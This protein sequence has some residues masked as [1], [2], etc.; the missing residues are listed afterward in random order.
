MLA[1]S[2]EKNST[3]YLTG[4]RIAKCEDS[5]SDEKDDESEIPGRFHVELVNSRITHL[6]GRL[7]VLL[8]RGEDLVK[9]SGS[10]IRGA[11]NFSLALRS[12][13]LFRKAKDMAQ[14]RRSPSLYDLTFL[15]E[16]DNTVGVG[17][18]TDCTG[19]AWENI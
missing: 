15:V 2:H 5:H 4:E 17:R 18:T 7:Q 12:L 11:G 19:S 8:C 13:L 1:W 16:K 9:S 14:L 10:S 6:T 3:E